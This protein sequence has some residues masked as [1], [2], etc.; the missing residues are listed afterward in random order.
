MLFG[1]KKEQE[2][3]KTIKRHSEQ[4][5]AV[6]HALHKA[7]KDYC[8]DC[9]DFDTLAEK[10]VSGESEADEIRRKVEVLLYDGA[11]MPSMRGDYANLV[12]SV[13][14]V[15]NQC[16]AVAQ[17]LLNTR[18]ELDKESRAGLVDI[19][20]ATVRCYDH[21]TEMYDKFEDGM[22][23]IDLAHKVEK[24]ERK[25][26]TLFAKIISRLFQAEGDLAKK[27]LA[28]MLFDRAAAI[29][30][31]IEDASDKFCVVVSKRP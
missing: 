1:R 31:R 18:P 16:E 21:I 7:V 2:T 27:I 4:V 5:G 11:F 24:K 28:K 8:A 15:A 9:A 3:E 19:M 14:K 13:D 26:D 6:V 29:S 23:V 10:V 22:A 25:V 30:N 20:K 17:F 12:E